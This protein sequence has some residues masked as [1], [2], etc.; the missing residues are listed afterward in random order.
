[1]SFC[2]NCGAENNPGSKFCFKCG[3]PIEQPSQQIY[4]DVPQGDFSSV[5]Q[6]GQMQQNYNGMPQMPNYGMPQGMPVQQKV[7]KPVNKKL[8]G[9]I[10]AVVVVVIA[11]IVAAVIIIKNVQHKREIE[12]KTVNL[13]EYIEVTFSGY[14]TMGTADAQINYDDF[15]EAVIKAMG[16]EVR[17]ASSNVVAKA[18]SVYYTTSVNLDNYSELSNGDKVTVDIKYDEEV[19]DDADIIISFEPYEVEVEG[20][21]EVREVDIFDYAEVTFSGMDGSAHVSV[22]NTATEEGLNSVWFDISDNSWELSIGDTVTVTVGDYYEEMLLENYGIKLASLS[23]EYTMTEDDVDQYIYQLS[24]I[25]DELMDT[26]KASALDEIEDQYSYSS[27]LELSDTEY[28]GSYLVYD[29]ESRYGGNILYII[30][31]ATLTVDDEDVEPMT[32]Y[33][34]V[35]LDSIIRRADGTQEADDTWYYVCGYTYIENTWL[36]F[37]GYDSEE[38][39]FKELIADDVDSYGYKYEISEGLTDYSQSS[40]DANTENETEPAEDET[41]DDKT[42]EDETS[43]E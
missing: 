32:V 22:N 42:S 17:S 28:Y 24:D 26:L 9:I 21:E 34:P 20:L 2:K 30:Y 16:K 38:T 10:I 29:D 14:D 13:E 19:I 41:A 43:E 12:R 15:Y 6:G 39:M 40:D 3:T 8:I 4:S 18:Q 27:G 35:Q 1:M 37:E 25:S 23:K 11:I 33:I 36:S 5:P 7:K 31:T